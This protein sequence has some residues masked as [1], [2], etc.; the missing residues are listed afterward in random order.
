MKTTARIKCEHCGAQFN[1]VMGYKIHHGKFHKDMARKYSG[2]VNDIDA[3]MKSTRKN[4]P[5]TCLVCSKK[6]KSRQGF[7][8]HNHACHGGL[9]QAKNACNTKGKPEKEAKKPANL[10]HLANAVL[11]SENDMLVPCFLKL[12]FSTFTF[13]IVARD[14]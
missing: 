10:N 6:F 3:P 8:K 4:R 7:G 1:N 9:A 2:N 5:C 12:N 14:E 11:P 13:D